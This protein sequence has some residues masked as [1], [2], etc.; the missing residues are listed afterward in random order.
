MTALTQLAANGPSILDVRLRYAGATLLAAAGLALRLGIAPQE[1]GLPYVSFFPAVTLAAIFFGLGPA[2]LATVLGAIMAVYYFIPP[3]GEVKWTAEA[4]MATMVFVADEILVCLAIEGMRHYYQAY[5]NTIAELMAARDEAQRANSAK[6]RFLAAASHDLRQPYQ[7]L[8]LYH[9]TL[10]AMDNA[11]MAAA[12]LEKMDMAMAA[13]EDLLRSL[14][15]VSSLE[16][17]LTV[18][19]REDVVLTDVIAALDDRHRPSAE[20]KGLTFNIRSTCTCRVRT[21]PVLLGRMLDNLVSNA[22]RY[23]ERGG[24]LVACRHRHGRPM[25]QVW[26]TGIGIAPENHRLVFEEFFQIGNSER[27]R[28]KGAGLGLAVVRKTVDL[29]GLKLALTSRPGHGTVFTVAFPEQG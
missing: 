21:D 29:L 27:D 14:L 18:P 16:A 1:F 7:A 24:V 12:V 9:A 19:K 22:V 17:G 8:R 23:T 20:A 25:V 4:A 2:A 26:D 10:S 28:T 13:G 6:S 5:E 3:F 11:P 15:D